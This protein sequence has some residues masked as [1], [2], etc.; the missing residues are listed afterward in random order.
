QGTCV[1]L[2]LPRAAVEQTPAVVTETSPVIGG[3]AIILL[4]EDDELVLRYVRGQLT[5][6]GYEVLDAPDG[7]TAMA[8]MQQRED[9]DL[10]FTDVVMSGGMS[11]P[12]L[13]E[14]A[15][16][17]RPEMKVLYTSGY[18]E[19][20]IVHRGRLRPGVRLLQKPYRRADLAAAIREALA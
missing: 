17:L 19:D 16:E 13:A 10:L 12:E 5:A 4:V 7:P 3:S 18:S 11:G 8:I 20:A 2:Y 6:L 1:D 14:A 9:I 15:S